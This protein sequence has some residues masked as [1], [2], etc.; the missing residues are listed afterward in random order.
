[1]FT[2]LLDRLVELP[3]LWLLFAASTIPF[4]ESLP[5]VDSF[6]PGEVGMSVLGAGTEGRVQ[7]L[8]PVIALAS[9][10]CFAGDCVG[11]WLGRRYGRAFFTHTGPLGARALPAVDR[12]GFVVAIVAAVV[13]I[14]IWLVRRRGHH[15]ADADE[16]RVTRPAAGAMSET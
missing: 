10:A 3:A 2:G 12:A 7:L 1:M 15:H 6:A 11:Y 8:A 14:A 5:L 16:P 9:V 4:V 13:V